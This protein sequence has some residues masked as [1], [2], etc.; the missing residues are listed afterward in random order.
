MENTTYL[1]WIPKK[2]IDN[3]KIVNLLNV[4]LESGRFTN[5]GPNVELLEKF[6]INKF[7]VEDTKAVIVVANGSVALHVL[8]S[9]INYYH[10]KDLQWATQ[11]FTFPASAQGTLSNVKILDNYIYINYNYHRLIFC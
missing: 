5:Y 8:T 3:K 4:C 11:S 1:D 7:H 2:E 10:K 6:I 9:A